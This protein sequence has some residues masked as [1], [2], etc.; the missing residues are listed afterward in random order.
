MYNVG[1]DF[2][3]TAATQQECGNCKDFIYPVWNGYDGF[4]EC[5]SCCEEV[6]E[7]DDEQDAVAST[8]I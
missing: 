7:E 6:K 5:P 8:F 1:P 4:W 2:T 3:Y